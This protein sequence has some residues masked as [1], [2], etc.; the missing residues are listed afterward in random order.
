MEVREAGTG[1]SIYGSEAQRGEDM[2]VRGRVV[3]GREVKIWR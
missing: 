2:K 1:R 3:S